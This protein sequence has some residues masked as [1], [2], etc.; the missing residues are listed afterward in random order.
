MANYAKKSSDPRGYV[1]VII[2]SK[3]AADV[4]DLP[5]G[6]EIEDIRDLFQR[7]GYEVRALQNL[8]AHAICPAI[9]RYAEKKDSHSLV[10][11][12]SSHGSRTTLLGSDGYCVNY[13]DIYQ[14]ANQPNLKRKPKTF[15][16]DACRT[17]YGEEVKDICIPDERYPDFFVGWACLG[18]QP[19]YPSTNY[20]G[21]YFQELIAVFK[22]NFH[23]PSRG[24]GFCRDIEHL[25]K[26]THY[27]VSEKTKEKQNQMPALGHSLRGRYFLQGDH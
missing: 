9:K 22:E 5:T 16:I 4:G 17:K 1:V 21:V 7:Y 15:F 2:N 27:R 11:F 25:V 12:I 13:V 19:S 23:L 14:A 6:N 3:F 18:S 8:C 24:H 10:C 20:C 26:I